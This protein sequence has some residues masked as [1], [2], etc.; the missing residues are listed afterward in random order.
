MLESEGCLS[1]ANVPDFDGE[2]A[3]CRGKHAFGRR[4]E[5]NLAN[6]PKEQQGQYKRGLTKAKGPRYLEW[7]PNLLMGATSTLTSASVCRVKP[8]GT[9]QM[10]TLPSSEA[11]ATILSL[12]GF[13]ESSRVRRGE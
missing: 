5:E 1:G 7:P 6:F 3:R 2:I 4:I 12:K 9:I 13:L 10:N 8:S 11:E